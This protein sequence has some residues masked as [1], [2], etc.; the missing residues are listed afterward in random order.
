MLTYVNLYTYRRGYVAYTAMLM[1]LRLCKTQTLYRTVTTVP[2]MPLH[3]GTKH[4][5]GN[6]QEAN[7][8]RPSHQSVVV[9]VGVDVLQGIRRLPRHAH[10]MDDVHDQKHERNYNYSASEAPALRSPTLHR[11]L[12]RYKYAKFF[13]PESRHTSRC[14]RTAKGTSYT[15][16]CS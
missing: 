15:P 8:Q 2:G 4:G 6:G 16:P 12:S 13:L 7:T 1:T 5:Q 3:I 14:T 9:Q 11:Q 10:D